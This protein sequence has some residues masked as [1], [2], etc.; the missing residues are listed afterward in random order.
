MASMIG[1]SRILSFT[2]EI[3]VSVVRT[4]A[5]KQVGK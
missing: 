1:R 2:Y 4:H 5:S 3:F